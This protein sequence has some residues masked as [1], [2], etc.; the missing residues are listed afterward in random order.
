MLNLAFMFDDAVHALTQ[1][2]DHVATAPLP[3]AVYMMQVDVINHYRHAVEHYLTVP[4][5]APF[6]QKSSIGTPYQKWAYFTNEDFEMLSFAIHNLLRY[7]SRLV[8]ETEE[9]LRRRVPDESVEDMEAFYDQM[10]HKSN[11]YTAPLSEIRHFRKSVG[12]T[13]H[14]D[15]RLSIVAMRGEPSEEAWEI[16]IPAAEPISKD[17]QERLVRMLETLRPKQIDIRDRSRLVTIKERGQVEIAELG[18]R[19][20]AFADLCNAFYRSRAVAQPFKNAQ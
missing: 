8:H 9:H 4:L 12:V 19:N 11:T 6:L 16:E 17:Q 13:V 14:D 18:S 20:R 3:A 2:G 1:Y 5:D 10:K 7:T 15:Q